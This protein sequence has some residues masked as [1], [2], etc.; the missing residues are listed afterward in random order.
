MFPHKPHWKPHWPRKHYNTTLP[1][2]IDNK[3]ATLRIDEFIHGPFVRIAING[4]PTFVVND[5]L[6]YDGVI[7]AVNRIILP[8]RRRCGHHGGHHH[9]HGPPGH[10]HGAEE[11]E[12]EMVEEMEEEWIEGFAEDDEWTIENLQRIFGEEE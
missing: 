4:R 11:E 8:R 12:G 7:Q 9:H 6:A 2:L 10:H 5:L 1:T 3:N